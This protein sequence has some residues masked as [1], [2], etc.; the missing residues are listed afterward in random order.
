VG[1]KEE[2]RTPW[3]HH[4]GWLE[5]EVEGDGADEDEVVALLIAGGSPGVVEGDGGS[6]TAYLYIDDTLEERYERIVAQLHQREPLLHVHVRPYKE[7]DWTARWKKF[8]KPIAVSDRLLIKPTW[9]E[10]ES[11]RDQVVVEIDPGMAFGT[12]HHP[13]TMMC[14][15]AVER[16][17][18]ERKIESVLDVGTGAGILAITAR[19]LGV[20]KAVGIDTDMTALKVAQK[21]ARLNRTKLTVSGT[22]VEKVRGRFPLVVANIIAEELVKIAPPL[23]RRMTPDGFLILSGILKERESEVKGHYKALGLKQHRRLTK[24]EWVCLVYRGGG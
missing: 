6:L 8:I 7:L 20:E 3:G 16:L 1:H 15:K 12:G 2:R 17:L 22:P 10:V 11:R 5:V 13:S 14:L 4:R 23:I 18:S 19:K 9:E 24:G 21:N